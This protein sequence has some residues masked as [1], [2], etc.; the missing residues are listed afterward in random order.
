[1][2]DAKIHALY[3]LL[4]NHNHKALIKESL[5]IPGPLPASLRSYSQI[6]LSKFSDAVNTITSIIEKKDPEIF[7]DP[8]ILQTL[9]LSLSL[10]PPSYFSV[11]DQ[12]SLFTS[13]SSEGSSSPI[14]LDSYI[15]LLL[16]SSTTD[17]SHFPTLFQLS[18]KLYMLTKRQKFLSQACMFYSLCPPSFQSS[19]KVLV[20]M[21]LKKL[22]SNYEDTRIKLSVL[23]SSSPSESL[24]ILNSCRLSPETIS[25]S[26]TIDELKST[27]GSCINLKQREVTRLKIKY[28]DLEGSGLSYV[29]KAIKTSTDDWE[30]YNYG[31]KISLR[32]NSV[33]TFISNLDTSRNATLSKI[34]LGYNIDITEYFIQY[35][36]SGLHKYL[37]LPQIK[38]LVSEIKKRLDEEE[39][40][41]LIVNRFGEALKLLKKHQIVP[42][43]YMV[44][45]EKYTYMSQPSSLKKVQ[46]YDSILEAYF[47]SNVTFESLEDVREGFKRLRRGV[48]GIERSE[49]NGRLGVEVV[50]CAGNWRSMGVHIFSIWNNLR[51]KQVQ[52]VSLGWIV[53][54]FTR[55][56][57]WAEFQRDIVRRLGESG[58]KCLD[59]GCFESFR[60]VITWW[61]RRFKRGVRRLEGLSG[62]V[63]G[64]VFGETL[65]E[66]DGV[67]GGDTDGERADMFL[68]RLGEWEGVQEVWNEQEWKGDEFTDERDPLGEEGDP[69]LEIQTVLTQTGRTLAVT[70][71]AV[72]ACRM[73]GKFKHPK[74]GKVDKKSFPLAE[75]VKEMKSKMEELWQ[76]EGGRTPTTDTLAALASSLSDF[77]TSVALNES[78]TTT[79][80]AADKARSYITELSSTLGKIPKNLHSTC[81][82]NPALVETVCENVPRLFIPLN[83]LMVACWRIG[84]KRK[85]ADVEGLVK[86]WYECLTQMEVILGEQ[87]KEDEAKETTT[88]LSP[89]NE[90]GAERTVEMLLDGN[91]LTRERVGT[92]FKELKVAVRD[93]CQLDFD[94]DF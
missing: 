29:I 6:K 76:R 17:S 1:M 53:K 41:E 52:T 37:T 42:E 27:T 63:V 24:E 81:I 72:Y 15:S 19:K 31:I 68:E 23:G 38:S 30:V 58:K 90:E 3:S 93:S 28:A 46:V 56:G 22:S 34:A 32:D 88:I 49:W 21:L 16:R 5:K 4:D 2:G 89:D 79:K 74:K 44:Y 48:R 26:T 83:A 39:A 59:N 14:Y 75:E 71:M 65:G 86:T 84:K 66:I 8:S 33:D 78:E 77:I 64:S 62:V 80:E 12:L 55:C 45:Y 85:T 82:L 25:D 11:S 69:A 57:M 73:V 7:Q 61:D 10:L 13:L 92:V 43:E 70:K 51:V 54:G 91:K 47:H 36:S 18:Q 35:G 87:P 20:N 67:Y 9:L 60:D 94:L 40:N 50:R